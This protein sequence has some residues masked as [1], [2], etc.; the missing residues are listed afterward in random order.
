MDEGVL[1]PWAAINFGDSTLAPS[2]QFE[3]PDPDKAKYAESLSARITQYHDAVARYR[4]NGFIVTGELLAALAASFDVPLAEVPQATETRAKIELA[5]TDIAKVVRVGE[6]RLSQGLQPLGDE[7]DLLTISEL[8]ALAESA[9]APET[10]P[11]V[12]TQPAL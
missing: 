12:G 1:A 9:P 8:T 4:D 11:A 6:A 3:F 2:R 7:R 5:P 10:T